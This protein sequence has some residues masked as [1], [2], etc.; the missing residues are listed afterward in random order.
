MAYTRHRADGIVNNL[1]HLY[2]AIFHFEYCQYSQRTEGADIAVLTEEGPSFRMGKLQRRFPCWSKSSR[3]C[4][5][6]E[7]HLLK[8][9]ETRP[10]EASGCQGA[11]AG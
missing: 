6:S 8:S 5:L 7:V 3:R 2:S 11:K 9:S 4:R 10:R 1:L